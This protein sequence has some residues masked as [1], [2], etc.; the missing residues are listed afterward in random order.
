MTVATLRPPRGVRNNNP[1]NLRR[2]RAAWLGERTDHEDPEFEAFER[3]EDG[4]RA[5]ARLL[6]RYHQARR[7]R[8]V[9]AI[10]S[11]YAPIAE[12]D[13]LG[14]AGAVARALGVQPDEPIDLTDP[15]V[16]GRM[17]KAIIRHENG[18]GPDGAD[19]YGDE[20]IAAGVRRA[21]EA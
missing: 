7:L 11:R 21:Q 3:P 20:Q 14:Y 9:G 4:I 12:N 16:L 19:W 5:L 6:L 10:I 17:V 8:T 15:D 2:T 13:T 18:R 1:G